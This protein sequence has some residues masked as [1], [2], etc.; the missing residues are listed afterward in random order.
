VTPRLGLGLLFDGHPW[1]TPTH[2]MGYFLP[3][4]RTWESPEVTN[5]SQDM[6]V[7]GA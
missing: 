4:L 3:V 5:E 7:R 2:A 6:T 1:L